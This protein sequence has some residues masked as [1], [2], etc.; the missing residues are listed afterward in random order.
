LEQRGCV[1]KQQSIQPQPERSIQHRHQPTANFN[2][3]LTYQGL[4]D[5]SSY[6]EQ[7][8]EEAARSGYNNFDAILNDPAYAFGTSLGIDTYLIDTFENGSVIKGYPE[9]ILENGGALNQQK[10]IQTSGGIYEVGLGYAANTND[11]FFFGLSVGIP[12][13]SYTRIRTSES[14]TQLTILPMASAI[15]NGMTS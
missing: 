5:L 14:R 11:K 6:S 4:N 15:L 2:N 3:T 13:V 7:F 9:F 1:W 12:I 8:A 10:T